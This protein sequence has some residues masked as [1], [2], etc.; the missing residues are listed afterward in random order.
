[1]TWLAIKAFLGRIPRGA[2]IGAAV[3][4]LLL[5]GS[6]VHARKV[7]QYGNERYA[8]GVKAE[9][10]RLAKK[11]AELKAKADAASAKISTALKEK[12]DAQARVIVRAADDLRLR[13]A[14]KA[15][16][17]RYSSISASPGRSVPT[18]GGSN[19]APAGLPD[20]DRIALPFGWTVDQAEKCD[21]NRSEVLTW[22]AWYAQQKEAWAKLAL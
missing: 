2:W 21:L 14:G 11:A 6:C 13:G 20:Q 10:D 3:V 4:A 12:N 15:A 9:G 8:A 1:M 7:K 18:S 17:P 5:L 16:C 22:R 19:V